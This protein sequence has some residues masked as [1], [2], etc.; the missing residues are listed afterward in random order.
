MDNKK[1]TVLFIMPRLPFP[2]ISGRK[3][4]LYHYCRIIS[5]N[6][7]YRLVVAAFLENDDTVAMKPNFIDRLEVLEISNKEKLL[8]IIKDSFFK[9]TK[10]IQ[11]SL[12]WSKLM[13]EKIKKIYDE[14]SPDYVIGDMVRTTEYIRNFE[15]VR[16]ADL[17][18]RISLRYK[19]QLMNDIEGINPYGAY[20]ENAPKFIKRLLMLKIIKRFIVKNEI[21]L[22]SKYELEIGKVCEKVIFV[23]QKEADNYNKEIGTNKAEA[24]PIGVDINYFEYRDVATENIIGFMG[25]MNVAHNDNAVRYFI[26]KIF[27]KILLEVKDAHLLVI[28]GGLTNEIKKME[29]KHIHFTGYVNDVRDYLEKCKVFVCPM[30]FGSGIKTKNLE[31]MSMGIPIVT[32]SIGAENIDAEIDKDWYVEDETH[33]FANK[34]INLLKN[35]ADRLTMKKNARKYIENNWTWNETR[36]ALEQILGIEK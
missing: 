20:I 36:K 26:E 34:V 30:T 2:A 24:V 8:N 33:M 4:S 5:E 31:A 14:E 1:K 27:P 15:A 25:A 11:V 16:I 21:S 29:S 23:A 22:L 32:T 6:L 19:R 18:D 9:R 3:T 12:Y 28:G 13:I 7:G 35:D 17:D 10:P